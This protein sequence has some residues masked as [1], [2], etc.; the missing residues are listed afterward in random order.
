GLLAHRGRLALAAELLLDR[1]VEFAPVKRRVAP[2]SLIVPV[3]ALAECRSAPA[4]SAPGLSGR[5]EPLEGRRVMRG[6]KGGRR[7]GRA[8]RTLIIPLGGLGHRRGGREIRCI[9][10]NQNGQLSPVFST[11]E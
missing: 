6:R 11:S 7:Y 1:L 10:C 8:L 9:R 3:G 4:G 2:S 5:D